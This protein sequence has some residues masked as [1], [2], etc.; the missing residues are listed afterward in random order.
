[1]PFFIDDY[2]NHRVYS[3]QVH[4]NCGICAEILRTDHEID[5]NGIVVRMP[6]CGHLFHRDCIL[7]SLKSIAKLRNRS[8]LYRATLCIKNTLSPEQEAQA[9][10]ELE[11]AFAPLNDFNNELYATLIDFTDMAS[12]R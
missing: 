2:L 1:M 4:D 10:H 9:R 6:P 3:E 12:M 8:L 7:K 11:L 5:K